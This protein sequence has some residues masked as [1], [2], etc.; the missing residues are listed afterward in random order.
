MISNRFNLKYLLCGAALTLCAATPALAQLEQ[1]TGVADPA[2]AG[3]QLREQLTMPQVSPDIEIKSMALIGAPEGAEN[4]TFNFGG[5]DVE[6]NNIYAAEE[7]APLYRDK[8]GTAITLADLYSIANQIT[9]KYRNDGYVLTQVVVPP[10][11]IESGI[12]RLQ[13]VEGYIQNIT[14]QNN[15]GEPQSAINTIEAYA[16]Q[17]KNEKALNI[18]DMERQLLLINDLPGMKARAIISPSA[19]PGAADM[20]IILSRK[21]YDAILTADNF[22]S[23]YLGQWVFGAAG[24]LNSVAG[25]NEAISGQFAYAPGSGHELL[26]GGLSYEQPIW[27]QGTKLSLLTS[28][29]DTDPGFDLAQFDVRGRAY[30][31]SIKV[32]HPVIRSRSTNLNARFA[33]DWDD[34]MSRNDIEEKRRDHIRSLRAGVQY[35]F[36]DTLLG[37]AVNN[38]DLELSQGIDVFDASEEGDA[39]LTR[40][41]GDPEYTKVTLA[42]QRLQRVTEDVNVQVTGR[43][44]ISNGPLLSSEEFAVGGILSGR[45]YDPSEIVGD[46]GVSGNV[47]AQ[48]NNPFV[49]PDGQVVKKY[50]LYTFYDIGKVWNDDATTSDDE[51]ESL[52]SAGAGVRLDLTNDF[53]AGLAVAFP[54]TRRVE[55]EDNR[56]ERVYFNISK[57]F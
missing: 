30:Q 56:D 39:N 48:W 38:M 42:V 27:T 7:L 21:P 18:K 3:D 19:T 9:L 43:G 52:A 12:A 51:S 50:Q 54:L 2:R 13:V 36:L 47:E 23:R 33:F 28:I 53:Q 14:V 20:L 10:Q 8:I 25:Q 44:Q 32:T 16:D 11:T 17:I 41:D 45:G 24:T 6:G 46:E 35:D 1:Q 37:V 5:L 22:G 34:V 31:H 15:E 49:E 57:K 26:Y 4:V 55:S 40:A 29:T